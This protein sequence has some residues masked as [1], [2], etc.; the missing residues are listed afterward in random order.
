MERII[1]ESHGLPMCDYW[2]TF[3]L[4]KTLDPLCRT[5]VENDPLKFGWWYFEA[6]V[7]PP[8]GTPKFWIF[9]PSFVECILYIL[10]HTHGN[11][12]AENCNFWVTKSGWECESMA[13]ERVV[14]WIY[15]FW[16]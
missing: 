5:S 1:V 9:L 13:A 14:A 4:G 15:D 16:D 3:D 10:H 8:P 2:G 6:T 12:R 11:L 7:L